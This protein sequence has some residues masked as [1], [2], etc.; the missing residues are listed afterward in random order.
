MIRLD[1]TQNRIADDLDALINRIS[2][3]GSAQRR[4]I[5][6]AIR[7]RFQE[8]FSRSA[9]GNGAWPSLAQSTVLDR[10]RQGYAGNRPILV[11]GGRLR[12]S[13]VNGGGSDHHGAVYQSG[14]FTIFE[15]GSQ[16]SIALF[17]E[18]GT[19]RM[20]QR[21]VTILD[22]GQEQRIA[23]VVD[24]AIRQIEQNLGIR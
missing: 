6:S 2:N 20:P 15:E 24:F 22:D 19:S 12:D 3:P 9:S 7:E 11:R 17:H 18:R 14:G 8:N 4:S 21:S 1:L 10:Q 23:D 5:S 13:Y 16:S